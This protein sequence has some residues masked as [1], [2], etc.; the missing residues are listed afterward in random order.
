MKTFHR[1]VLALTLAVGATLF[2]PSSVAHAQPSAVNGVLCY[3]L[4]QIG[5][6]IYPC[7]ELFRSLKPRERVLPW[8]QGC[9]ACLPA[10]RFRLN[11]SVLDEVSFLERFNRG[12]ALLW[13]A[14]NSQGAAERDRLLREAVGALVESTRFL[15]QSQVALATAGYLEPRSRQIVEHQAMTPVGVYLVEGLRGIQAGDPTPQPSIQYA[16]SRFSEAL[17]HLAVVYGY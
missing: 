15:G 12:L 17:R 3:G 10:V 7:Y 9:P 11:I 6:D 1:I 4:G 16:L 8:E 5:L 2:A 13:Q 14:E